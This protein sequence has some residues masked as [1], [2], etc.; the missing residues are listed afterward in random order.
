MGKVRRG[1]RRKR[2]S[3]DAATTPDAAAGDGAGDGAKP[4]WGPFASI[5]AYISRFAQPSNGAMALELAGIVCGNTYLLW[6]V[7]RGDLPTVGIVLLVV[8][9]SVLLA[10]VAAVQLHFIPVAEQAEPEETELAMRIYWWM[11][12]V[13]IFGGAYFLWADFLDELDELE[14]FLSSFAPWRESGLHVAL[15]IGLLFALAG[16][17]ADHLHY[18]RTGPPFISSVQVEATARR[19]TFGYGIFLMAIPIFGMVML[20][21]WV[22]PRLIKNRDSD[23]WNFIGGLSI[24]AVFYASCLAVGGLIETGPV[25]WAGMYLWSKATI[26]CGFVALPFVAARKRAAMKATDARKAKKAKGAIKAA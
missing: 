15:G 7:W 3:A 26:E 8:A 23:K 17:V 9:E 21:I 12:L 14:A 13:V 18:R 5:D 20:A 1:G 25:G 2:K 22:V 24:I 10:L 6:C 11:G 4:R 16:V 19:M